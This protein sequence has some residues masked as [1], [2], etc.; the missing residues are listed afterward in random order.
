MNLPQMGF[1]RTLLES[2]PDGI[3]MPRMCFD[4]DGDFNLEW[5]SSRNRGLVDVSVSQEGVISWAA[6]SGGLSKSGSCQV[7][8]EFPEDIL[9]FIRELDTVKPITGSILR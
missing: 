5:M 1:A 9:T 2:L 6:I 3:E 7:A 8:S 4:A